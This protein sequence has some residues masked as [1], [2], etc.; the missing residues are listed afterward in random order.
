M[1]SVCINVEISAENQGQAD[2][3]MNALLDRKLV[4]GGQ[5]LHAP[6]RFRWKGEIVDM[7][8]VTITSFTIDKH[9]G[10]IVEAASELS[11]E[12]IPMI[13]FTDFEANPKLQKWIE[14]TVA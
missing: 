4:T 8:Y 10:A 14:D 12:S 3:I 11:E 1:R 13:R 2:K 5:F 9:K 7:D 6:A